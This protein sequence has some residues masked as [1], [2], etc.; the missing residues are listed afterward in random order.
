MT[1]YHHLS[2]EERAIIMLEQRRGASLR[3]I[4]AELNRSPSTLCRELKRN[5][6]GKGG[7]HVLPSSAY[8]MQKS[9]APLMTLSREDNINGQLQV[10]LNR[11]S[12]LLFFFAA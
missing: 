8:H 10:Y 3:S 12:N 4:A 6:S 7:Y 11:L 5:Q 2:A 1:T 9:G